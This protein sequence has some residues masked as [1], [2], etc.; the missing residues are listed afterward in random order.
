MEKS[1]RIPQN[2]GTIKAKA[3]HWSRQSIAVSHRV[4]GFRWCVDHC[5]GWLLRLFCSFYTVEI[6]PFAVILLP[7]AA[8]RA[9][10][11]LRRIHV[12]KLE[13]VF[14]LIT[15]FSLH[16]KQGLRN[17][18]SERDNSWYLFATRNPGATA[19]A[20]Q[21]MLVAPANGLSRESNK[22]TLTTNTESNT[23]FDRNE[24]DARMRSVFTGSSKFL[25]VSLQYECTS[26]ANY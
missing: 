5:L 15:K 17:S 8:H 26:N 18:E 6:R 1:N 10:P 2:F 20:I 3:L 16:S 4:E 22:R 13:S 11:C 9:L 7:N 23:K 25:N 12:E 21:A 14:P 24:K 19:A